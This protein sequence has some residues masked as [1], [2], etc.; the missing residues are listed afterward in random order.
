M[1]EAC[2]IECSI[3]TEKR[4]IRMPAVVHR[5]CFFL[6]HTKSKFYKTP[7]IYNII[8]S[9][10]TSSSSSNS[11]NSKKHKEKGYL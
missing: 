1:N 7:N 9:S 2:C 11:T 4:Y 5:S 10:T 8:Y 3:T 6:K